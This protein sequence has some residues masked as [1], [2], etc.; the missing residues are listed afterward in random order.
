MGFFIKKLIATLFMPMSIG[1]LLLLVSFIF[2]LKNSY[3]RAKIFLALALLWFMLL[4]SQVISNLLLMPLENTYEA[5]LDTPQV[6]YILVLGNA[7]T[8]N[9]KL[10]ITSQ[11]NPTSI[12][13]LVE[14]IRHYKNLQNAK[15]IVSGYGGSDVNSHAIMQE[16]LAISLGVKKEDI[17]RQ[18]TP[19]DTLDEA[20]EL[21]KI[22]K[23]EP[24]ILVT[25]ASHMPRSVA[26]FKKEGLNFIP[27]PTNHK[28]SWNISP[29]SLFN[30]NNFYKSDIAMHEYLGLL[31]AYIKGDI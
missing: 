8:T 11:L 2:L 13:R 7:H 19:Q 25:S 6:K 18:D 26:L 14:G 22:V 23:N 20:R 24:F 4:S 29:D 17:I 5:L 30:S 28:T 10:S 27:A 31:Y 12:N 3:K 15:L 9:E 16:K 21:K 1:L